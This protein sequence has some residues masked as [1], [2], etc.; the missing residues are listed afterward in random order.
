LHALIFLECYI[1]RFMPYPAHLAQVQ[2]LRE[3][4]YTSAHG[5][6]DIAHSKGLLMAVSAEM[7]FDPSDLTVG[8][9]EGVTLLRALIR[10][11][12]Q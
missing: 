2:G 6:C 1:H 12:V 3:M 11:I 7:Q 4:E 10:E 8:L 5:V 9:F